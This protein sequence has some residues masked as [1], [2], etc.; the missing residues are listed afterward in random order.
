MTEETKIQVEE[1][2]INTKIKDM[3]KNIKKMFSTKKE[4]EKIR[5]CTPKQ[6]FW[7]RNPEKI[8]FW[9]SLSESQSNVLLGLKDNTYLPGVRITKVVYK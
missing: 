5:V 3:L 9:R 7:V 1:N 4:I 6:S 2:P 8:K